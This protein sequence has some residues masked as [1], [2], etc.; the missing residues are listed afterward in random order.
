MASTYVEW[1]AEAKT[2][3]THDRRI[4]TANVWLSEGTSRN[5]KYERTR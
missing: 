1:I 4:A 3:S 2:A 5:W